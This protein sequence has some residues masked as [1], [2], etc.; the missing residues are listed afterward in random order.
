MLDELSWWF[1]GQRDERSLAFDRRWGT[2]TARFDLH[3]YE[4]STPD[5]VDSVLDLLDVGPQGWTFLDLGSG[6][7]RAVLLASQRPFR[8]AVGIEWRRGLHRRAEANLAAFRARGGPACPVELHCGDAATHALPDGPLV[9]YLYNPF[10]ANVVHDV[11]LRLRGRE[12]RLCYVN[13]R[14]S[15][16]VEAMGY[17]ALREAEDGT[18]GT[19]RVFAP[20]E[21]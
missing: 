17:R 16:L 14:E 18:L 4:P 15:V 21:G 3:N 6:K 1:R 9:V 20:G 7:G 11:L 8:R 13:P 12:H 19:F 5:V 10:P 2:E